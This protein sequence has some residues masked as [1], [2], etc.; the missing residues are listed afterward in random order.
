MHK[1][2]FLGT[3]LIHALTI[4][5]LTF[6]GES[7]HT[8]SAGISVGD[9]SNVSE[10]GSQLN[11]LNDSGTTHITLAYDY[12][13]NPYFSVGLGYLDG[14][15]GEIDVL[16]IDSFTDTKI[17]YSAPFLRSTLSYPFSSKNSIFI[18]LRLYNYT[19]DVYDDYEV[20]YSEKDHD[21]GYFV[22]WKRVFNSGIGFTLGYERLGLGES[23]IVSGPNINIV[24][25]F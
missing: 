22:G 13:I 15:S 1:L 18:G 20:I 24:Y 25:R 17:T 19:F 2:I 12:N 23:I 9:I 10:Y 3:V 7:K 14:D 21:F 6:A 8:V 16:L 11:E 5:T 4:S